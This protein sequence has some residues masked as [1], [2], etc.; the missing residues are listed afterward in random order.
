MHNSL[1]FFPKVVA[2]YLFLYLLL[3]SHPGRSSRE[4]TPPGIGLNARRLRSIDSLLGSPWI[5]RAWTWQ[6]LILAR[7]AIIISGNKSLSWNRFILAISVLDLSYQKIDTWGIG[8][9]P[10]PRRSITGT[11]MTASIAYQ[12]IV[13]SFPENTNLG[14]LNTWC[15]LAECWLRFDRP[16]T[17]T[18]EGAGKNLSVLDR[19]FRIYSAGIIAVTCLLICPLFVLVAEIAVYIWRNSMPCPEDY[20][21]FPHLYNG[22]PGLFI[23]LIFNGALVGY[24]LFIFYSLREDMKKYCRFPI[25]SA[26]IPVLRTRKSTDPRDICYGFYGVLHAE[27]L[28]HLT[29]PDYQSDSR[30]VFR[31][32]LLDL[33][34]WDSKALVLLLDCCNYTEPSWSPDW[35]VDSRQSWLDEAYFFELPTISATPTSTPYFDVTDNRLGLFVYGKQVSQSGVVWT[36]ADV[37]AGEVR[38]P[39]AEQ[40]PDTRNLGILLDWIRT[41]IQLRSGQATNIPHKDRVQI[42]EALEKGV[43]GTFKP[44]RFREEFMSWLKVIEPYAVRSETPGAEITIQRGADV[45]TTHPDSELVVQCYEKLLASEKALEYHRRICDSIAHQRRLFIHSGPAGFQFGAGSLPME[46]GDIVCLISGLPVPMILR[47]AGDLRNFTRDGHEGSAQAF[48]VIG[49]A[50]ISGMMKGE[51]WPKGNNN[52]PLSKDQMERFYLI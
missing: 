9:V 40:G 33:I 13:S 24:S 41:R 39:S 11:L 4:I 2:S 38:I 50:F 26:I 15:F 25:A 51:M 7:K 14:N 32:F 36:G 31:G 6:E 23:G 47:K 34:Q 29:S 43:A 3:K 52:R 17:M 18:G 20:I 49:P 22:L 8:Q 27:G 10:L 16:L 28:R 37:A 30:T 35:Q 46:V 44:K 21:C 45:S 5:Q 1:T 48:S 12:E 19:H 42:F